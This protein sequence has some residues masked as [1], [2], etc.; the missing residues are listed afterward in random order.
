MRARRAVLFS[1][2][3]SLRA[4]GSE[5]AAAHVVGE[6][7]GF[8]HGLDELAFVRAEAGQGLEV[9]AEVV[10]GL[11]LAGVEEQHVGTHGESDGEAAEGVEGGL[12][13]ARLVAAEQGGVETGALGECLLG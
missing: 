4:G 12:N 2:S 5:A 3:S 13:L 9:E 11:A 8:D 10:T 1:C 7:D 6:H